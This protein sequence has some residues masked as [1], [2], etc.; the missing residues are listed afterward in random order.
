MPVAASSRVVLYG[1][2]GYTG[3]LTAREMARRGMRPVLA[4]R[5][6]KRLDKLAAELGGFEVQVADV[7]DPPSVAALVEEGDVLV[8]TVGPYT[9]WGEPA[10]M[11]A[12]TKHAHYLDATGESTFIRRVFEFAGPRAESEGVALLTAMGFDWVPGNLAG[13]LALHEA[14]AHARRV[15]IGYFSDTSLAGTGVTSAISGGT[16]ATIASTMLDSA[17]AYREGRIARERPARRVAHF[18]TH[19][20]REEP[21]LSVGS[22]EHF[23][24][25]RLAAQLLEVDVYI[26]GT[27]AASRPAQVLAAGADAAGRIPGTKA[28]LG[29]VARRLVRGSSGGPSHASRARVRSLVTATAY[30]LDGA[31]LHSVRL[32]GP[33][34]YDLTA[35]F[36]AWGAERIAAGELLSDG[37]IGPVEAFGLE[38]LEGAA[39]EYGLART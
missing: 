25:P 10:L 11:A 27:G 39:R 1:A 26:G 8:T 18:A 34:G 14:G 31:E 38:E 24:L 5:A 7:H 17:F 4:G 30:D 21:A 35:A 16:R 6:R 33:N 9:R 3:E 32:E 37:A 12:L 2:T 36:L 13:T 15:R 29:F 19:D 22:S 28:G 23:T 20:G